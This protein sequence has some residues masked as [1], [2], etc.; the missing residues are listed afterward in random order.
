MKIG[1]LGNSNNY[2]FRLAQALRALGH[3][4]VFFVD[5]PRSEPRH[6]P[7][8]HYTD[9]PYPYPDWIREIEPLNPMQIVLYPWTLRP[10]L[11]TLEACDG[12]VLNG[13]ALSVG[14][15]IRRPIIGWLSGSDLDVYANS[16]LIDVLA[17]GP[18]RLDGFA[19]NGL[20]KR[21]LFICKRMLFT[22]FVKLQ[23]AGIAKCCSMEYAIPGLLPAG[24]A[25]LDEIGVDRKRRTSFM[26]TDI[27]HLPL[28]RA[29]T[30]GIFR[31]F[32]AARLQWKRSAVGA[33][34]SPLD[35]K[36]T[37]VMLEG[38]R[39]FVA[40]SRSP[41][42]I[43]LISFG[44]D[45]E[46]AE[47]Y[48]EELGLAPY[49]HWHPQLTQAE[50]LDEMAQADVV[51]ENFG[52]DGCMG[53]AGRDAIAMGKPLIT[54]SNSAVFEQVLGEPLPIYEALLPEEICARLEEVIK[55]DENVARKSV[56]A[57]VFAERWF[58]ARRAADHCVAVFEEAQKGSPDL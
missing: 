19:R 55:N 2:P 54:W 27:E 42:Q 9:V 32:C 44:E 13:L 20:L 41:M 24:D 17:A 5:R 39:M 33:N 28:P 7:E 57:K 34:V 23:R 6:R 1:F 45:A 52:R 14:T 29:R 49:V 31:I 46:A 30:D 16:R 4:V 53:M 26:I 3:E 58:S 35:M 51:L 43:Y 8:C 10:V 15:W 38:L 50:F 48:A 21:I 22:R 40:R 37:D 11:R 18:S 36:G 56:Q 12:V 47:R 25:L